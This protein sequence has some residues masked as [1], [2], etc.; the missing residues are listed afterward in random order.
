[1]R[2]FASLTSLV[3]ASMP[4]LAHADLDFARA[5]AAFQAR[6]GAS[7][8]LPRALANA[9]GD[10]VGLVLERQVPDA[11]PPPGATPLGGDFFGLTLPRAQAS[12]LGEVPGFIVH[13]APERH[14]LLDRALAWCKVPEFRAAF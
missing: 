1:M 14:V 2:R 3:L 4:A 10:R 5:R 12:G 11:P 6:H 13:W 9:P 8:A 7:A